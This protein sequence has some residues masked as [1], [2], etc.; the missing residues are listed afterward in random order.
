MQDAL[1]ARVA[2]TERQ[3]EIAVRVSTWKER[4]EDAMEEQVCF[5]NM[6]A[7][8]NKCTVEVLS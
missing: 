1:L 5:T 3:S 7:N 4:I 2:D 6:F 8:K